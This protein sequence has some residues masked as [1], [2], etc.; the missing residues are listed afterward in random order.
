[1][2]KTSFHF[3]RVGLAIT[4]LWIGVLIFKN[5][6]SWGGYLQP[7]AV[8][9]LPIPPEQAMIGTAILD[10][11]IGAFLL[12]DFLPWLAALVGA[13]HLVVV[14]TVSSIT[15]ITVRDIGLLAAALAVV[16]DSL[17]QSIINRINF[18][19]KLT[20]KI[21]AGDKSEPIP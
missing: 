15:D 2:K 18:L 5:P 10:I 1:M 6:E 9:L 4:F 7:W 16:I 17:P 20:P 3:L 14:L 11:T 13:I 8:W 21:N 19:K 12:I